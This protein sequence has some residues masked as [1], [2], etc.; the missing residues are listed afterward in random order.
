MKRRLG[1][2]GETAASKINL[3]KHKEKMLKDVATRKAHLELGNDV[4]EAISMMNSRLLADMMV[5]RN[6]RFGRYLNPDELE[7]AQ[8]PESAILDTS[9]W[10]HERVAKS[11]PDF[12]EHFALARGNEDF[13]NLSETVEKPGA[14]HTLVL[15][16]AALRAAD[17]AR[18]LKRF[19]R[20]DAVVA[21]L[22]AKHIKLGDAIEYVKVT[23][24]NIGVGT[25]SRIFD[26]LIN[27]V[28][29]VESL[30]RLVIDCSFLD[31]KKR[32]ILDMKETQQPLM[33]LLTREELKSR[34][35]S[36]KAPTKILFY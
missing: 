9:H 18:V 7:D 32:G 6:Q 1:D 29:S 2:E 23:R 34:Y 19:Q 28:L 33:R 5:Q 35:N 31:R 25:P 26:L 12:L 27:G 30:K 22:F 4:D 17:L 13:T 20:K 8:I 21:K 15:T 36:A 3:A 16:G 11:L 24:M 10:G 14:P